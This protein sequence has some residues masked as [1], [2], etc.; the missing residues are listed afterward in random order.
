M[1][2][3]VRSVSKIVRLLTDDGQMLTWGIVYGLFELDF[4]FKLYLFLEGAR[5]HPSKPKFYSY[6]DKI[7]ITCLLTRS[8]MSNVLWWSTFFLLHPFCETWCMNSCNCL[9]QVSCSYQWSVTSNSIYSVSSVVTSNGSL[10]SL[11]SIIK[12]TGKQR[13]AIWVF[14]QC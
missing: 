3:C 1:V 2:A 9:Q 6:M 11:R 12:R 8:W 14:R 10:L 13:V 5:K 4:L 7:L